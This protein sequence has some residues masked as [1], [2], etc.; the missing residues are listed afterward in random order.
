ML[1][2]P[3]P[4]SSAR[5]RPLTGECS[6]SEDSVEFGYMRTAFKVPVRYLCE[7][8]QQIREPI[9]QQDPATHLDSES[10]CLKMTIKAILVG[11][12]TKGQCVQ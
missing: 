1:A 9:R 11:G 10:I 5:P 8:I 2:S 12:I 4:H 6:F 7:N 3:G